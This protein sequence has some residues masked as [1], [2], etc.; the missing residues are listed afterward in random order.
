MQSVSPSKAPESWTES[1]VRG[2]LELSRNQPGEAARRWLEADAVLDVTAAFDPLSAAS[3]SNAGAARLL[4][5]HDHEA[6]LCFDAAEQFW[7]AA[8]AGIATLDVPM[9]GASSSFHFRLA[10]KAPEALIGARRDRYR[11]LAGSALAITQFNRAFASGENSSPAFVARRAAELK[12]LLRDV[13]GATSPEARLLVLCIE[14]AA[15][16]DI[17]AIYA[18]KVSE[19]T[20]RPQ[21]LTATLS[22]ACARLESAIAL[23]ALLALPLLKSARRLGD[24]QDDKHHQKRHPLE[25][26]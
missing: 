25:L 26:E 23:T 18:D 17:N 22:E 9:T 14:P 1:T 6:E 11:C 4:L 19:I 12:P 16:A 2:F 7:R 5:G 10:A 8:I 20:L 24:A 21:T 13:L 3:R 15:G